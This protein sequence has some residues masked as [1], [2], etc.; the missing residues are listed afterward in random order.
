MRWAEE[1]L[2]ALDD[3]DSRQILTMFLFYP[4]DIEGAAK[5]YRTVFT[6]PR[7]RILAMPNT[8]DMT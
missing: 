7:K 4:S 3:M 2:C 1:F 5:G 6:S 8:L